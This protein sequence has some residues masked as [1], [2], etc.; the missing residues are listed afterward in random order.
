MLIWKMGTRTQIRP[1]YLVPTAMKRKTKTMKIMDWI[2]KV[3]IRIKMKKR[4]KRNKLLRKKLPT[5][6]ASRSN[7]KNLRANK[8]TRT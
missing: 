8:N 5:T 1:E 2:M 6:K 7:N 3:K 4:L